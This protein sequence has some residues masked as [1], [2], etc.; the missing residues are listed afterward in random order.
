MMTG[1]PNAEGTVAVLFP[2]AVGTSPSEPPALTCYVSDNPSDGTWIAVND[3]YWVTDSEWCALSFFEGQWGAAM[4][5]VL[6]GWTAAF[7]VFY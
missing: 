7:V 1:V 5:N 3:G 2:T 4:F 6:A